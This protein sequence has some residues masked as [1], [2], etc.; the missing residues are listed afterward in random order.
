VGRGTTH[1]DS[2]DHWH[3]TP[4]RSH[5]W[6]EGALSASA[7]SVHTQQC[8]HQPACHGINCYCSSNA[9]LKGARLPVGAVARLR[10]PLCGTGSARKLLDPSLSGRCGLATDCECARSLAM[11]RLILARGSRILRGPPVTVPVCTL[12]S[13]ARLRLRVQAHASASI[14]GSQARSGLTGQVRFRPT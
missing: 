10:L 2:D 4:S 3:L 13:G 8:G 12:A 5:E 11:K 6:S 1:S 9:N 14:V 7:A